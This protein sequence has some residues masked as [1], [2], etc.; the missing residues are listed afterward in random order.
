MYLSILYFVDEEVVQGAGGT[1]APTDRE[2]LVAGMRV[3]DCLRDSCI[4]AIFQSWSERRGKVTS[5]IEV[6]QQYGDGTDAMSVDLCNKALETLSEYADWIDIAFMTNE[7]TLQILF[8]LL[9][10]PNY[11]ENVLLCFE[12]LVNK[13]MPAANKI[14]LIHSL[15]IYIL[16]GIA[17]TPSPHAT[18]SATASRRN[19]TPTTPTSPPPFWSCSWPW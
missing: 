17:Y 9:G 15:R 2:G 11:V 6:L 8:K 18:R 4:G 12:E 19:S 7:V 1:R 16:F 10:N 13:G 5:R 14:H 3:K